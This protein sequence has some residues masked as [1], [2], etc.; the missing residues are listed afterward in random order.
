MVTS[1]ISLNKLQRWKKGVI[2]QQKKVKDVRYAMFLTYKGEEE[3]KDSAPAIT[4]DA[5][6]NYSQI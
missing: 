3:S 5:T 1:V 4:G 6:R 2:F